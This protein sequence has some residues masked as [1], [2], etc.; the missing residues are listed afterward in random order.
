MAQ[1]QGRAQFRLQA[2]IWRLTA[3]CATWSRIA[4]REMLP[5]RVTARKWRN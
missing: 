5:L 4:A 3:D 1:E 2:E